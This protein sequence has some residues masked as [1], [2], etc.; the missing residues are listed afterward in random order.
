MN[1]SSQI[2]KQSIHLM[3]YVA[4][5]LVLSQSM[6]A[7]YQAH[8]FVYVGIFL[9]F[10]QRTHLIVQLLLA[11]L[12]G[13]IVDAFYN[14]L[15]IHAFASVLMVYM[16]SFLGKMLFP[17]SGSSDIRPSITSMGFKHF[18]IF[19]LIP[20]F[21]HHTAVFFLEAWDS[22]LTLLTLHKAILSTLLT[23]FLIAS[24]Q[25]VAVKVVNK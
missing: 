12:V 24:V 5:Q 4:L 22:P 23:Y 3:S 15:G 9:L 20:L 19:I 11:F 6:I 1:K 10:W 25:A 8:G 17:L 2:L 18:S 13:I 7:S 14:T 16:Q 21:I